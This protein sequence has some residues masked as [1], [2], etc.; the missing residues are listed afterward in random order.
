[1]TDLVPL[2]L[3]PDLD[4]ADLRRR[5]V[6]D[7]HVRVRRVFTRGAPEL[8]DYLSGNDGWIQLVNH[9]AGAHEIA[10][11]DWQAPNSP[12]RLTLEP[13][14]FARAN[15]EFQ[16]SY[17]ALRI[18]TIGEREENQVLNALADLMRDDPMQALLE[19]ITT[20]ADPVFTDGQVTAYGPGDFLT[21]HDDDLA[22]S[23]RKVAFV[24]GLTPQWRFEWGGLL[25]FHDLGGTECT[26]LI[27][28]FN[29]LDLFA[30]PRYH[31][32]SM[33]TRAAPRRRFSVTGWL[34]VAE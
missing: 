14:I 5:F 2:E 24:L 6:H 7:G 19:G 1:V 4:L 16:Y 3:N 28:Q 18:P 33:V 12:S 27:P 9:E 13:Q 26:G 15:Q 34:S 20:L 31:S 8:Y 32:V 11:R 30:I 29:T 10:W 21:G 17:A 22:G 23:G 25:L